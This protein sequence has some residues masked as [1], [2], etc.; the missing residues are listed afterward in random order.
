M[1]LIYIPKGNFQATYMKSL[2]RLPVGTSQL[3]FLHLWLALNKELSIS[4]K[5]VNWKIHSLLSAYTRILL[6]AQHLMN[7]LELLTKI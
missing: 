7:F 3:K 2:C 6:Y 5:A 4:K 1:Q